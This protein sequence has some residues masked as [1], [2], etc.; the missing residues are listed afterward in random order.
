M[1]EVVDRIKS[2]EQVEKLTG[3]QRDD[4][5]TQLIMGEDVI[6]TINTSRGDFQVKF[7]KVGD[8]ITIGR[9]ATI[10]RGNKPPESFDAES[11][12]INVMASTLD[13]IVVSG[14]KWFEDAKAKNKNFSFLEVPSRAFLM[15]LYGKAYSFREE[16]EQ[17]LNPPKGSAVK[18]VSTTAGNDASVGGGA[19]TGISGQPG[20]TE[21]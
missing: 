17:R 9:I 10:R 7:P 11:E 1:P 14:P 20:D 8:I 18:P 21:T 5:F 13:T 2:S 6:E 12:M 16:I 3:E 4:L 19:F 15:E